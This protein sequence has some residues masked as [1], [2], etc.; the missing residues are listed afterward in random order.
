LTQGVYFKNQ[1]L[2]FENEVVGDWLMTTHTFCH[3]EMPEARPPKV[4]LAAH[5]AIFDVRASGG[6][7][8]AKRLFNSEYVFRLYPSAVPK[9][10]FGKSRKSI[11]KM[12]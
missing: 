12:H 6:Q 1:P 5:R 2:E 10:I 8:V 4:G 9:H 7:G 3:P 11:K